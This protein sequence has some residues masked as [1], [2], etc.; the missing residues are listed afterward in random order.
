MNAQIRQM[1]E[2]GVD[3]SRFFFAS[4]VYGRGWRGH[5]TIDAARS[6]AARDSARAVRQF[7]GGLPQHLVA[8]TA[9]GKTINGK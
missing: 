5:A 3:R 9:S 2:H 1:E 8:E 4:F 6:S 7:G